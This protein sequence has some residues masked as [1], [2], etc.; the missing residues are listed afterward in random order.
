MQVGEEK[1][2]GQN[3]ILLTTD[4]IVDDKVIEELAGK[5]HIFSV[6]RIEL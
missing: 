1:D 3:V 6:R 5:D 4:I 2:K